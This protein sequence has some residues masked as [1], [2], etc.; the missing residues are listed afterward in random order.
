MNEARKPCSLLH[1]MFDYIFYI[2]AQERIYTG[3]PKSH[4]AG[5]HVVGFLNFVISVFLEVQDQRY[6]QILYLIDYIA[7][8]AH[9]NYTRGGLNVRTNIRHMCGKIFGTPGQ[10]KMRSS[11]SDRWKS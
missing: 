2:V 5:G 1:A 10:P 9:H 11:T 8:S 6:S 4:F 7:Y 3:V